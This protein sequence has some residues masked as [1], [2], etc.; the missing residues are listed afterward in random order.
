MRKQRQGQEAQL[1]HFQGAPMLKVG[2]V[3]GGISF[4]D[5]CLR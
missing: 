5:V 1:S 3:T 2:G 4:R